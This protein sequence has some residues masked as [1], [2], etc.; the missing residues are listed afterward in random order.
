MK[1]VL[2]IDEVKFDDVKE[3]GL[4]TPNPSQIS[5]QIGAKKAL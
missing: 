5:D 2:N 4:Y 1:P 3:N